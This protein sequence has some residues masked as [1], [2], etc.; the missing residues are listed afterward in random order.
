[1]ADK[2][3]HLIV[4][5]NDN[6]FFYWIASTIRVSNLIIETI[7]QVAVDAISDIKVISDSDQ[8][9]IIEDKIYSKH[10]TKISQTFSSI[11]HELPLLVVTEAYN[12]TM[13]KINAF[14]IIDTIVKPSLSIHSLEH[15]IC[16][17]LKDYKLTQRLKRLAHYDSL[18]G[19]ANRYLFDD[20]M[21]EALKKAKREKQAFSLLFFDLNAF[22]SVNDNY[23]HEVGDL[24]LKHFVSQLNKVRRE[25]D[26]LAR[27][28]GDEFCMLLPNTDKPS[29]LKLVDRIKEA[30]LLPLV[31]LGIKLHIQ[32]AIG[33]VNI[34]NQSISLLSPKEI[35]KIADKCVYEAK[36]TSETHLVLETI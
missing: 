34:Q 13:S 23:G 16:S 30:F 10:F 25:T 4:V 27:L 3:L 28:G 14:A 24:L 19:A 8:L 9:L 33:G 5:T 26:T 7:N 12:N 17:L 32:S 6:D 2:R 15:A 20:R 36:K 22:K 11:E 18:T 31:D 1:M 21:S 29:L 35:L